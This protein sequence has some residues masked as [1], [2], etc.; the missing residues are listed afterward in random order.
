[1]V[2]EVAFERDTLDTGVCHMR[3]H[4]YTPRIVEDG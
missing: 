2:S 4:R 1:M 3:I